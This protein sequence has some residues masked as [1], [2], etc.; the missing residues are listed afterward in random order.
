M[1]GKK[2]EEE[3]SSDKVF[4]EHKKY[5]EVITFFFFSINYNVLSLY[6]YELT[7]LLHDPIKLPFYT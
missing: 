2:E 5:F 4:K 1:R 7:T 3:M 6:S